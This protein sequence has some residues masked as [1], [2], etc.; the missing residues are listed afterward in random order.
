MIMTP[1]KSMLIEY[2]KIKLVFV[3]LIDNIKLISFYLGLKVE[4]NQEQKTIK[5]SQVQ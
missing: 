4:Q 3:F 1:K 2:I 5:L